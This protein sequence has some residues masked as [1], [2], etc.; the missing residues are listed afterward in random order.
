MAFSLENTL[1]GL[2]KG[3]RSV[4]AAPFVSLTL[5]VGCCDPLTRALQANYRRN[6]LLTK[7]S[8]IFILSLVVLQ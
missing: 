1:R 4:T 7:H 5:A 3:A 2:T 6:Q 8:S